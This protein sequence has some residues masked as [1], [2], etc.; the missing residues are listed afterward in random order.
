MESVEMEN[1]ADSV[2][3]TFFLSYDC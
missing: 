1:K 2:V 3:S